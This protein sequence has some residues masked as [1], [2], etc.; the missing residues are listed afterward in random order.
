MPNLTIL[1]YI[2][3][4][5]RTKNL[6]KNVII[7]K[8]FSTLCYATYPKFGLQTGSL[9]DVQKCCINKHNMLYFATNLQRGS[10]NAHFYAIFA[11]A[12]QKTCHTFIKYV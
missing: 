1:R 9:V 6:G 5:S 12:L 2:W 3:Q 11:S 4:E 10:R 8:I 7:S